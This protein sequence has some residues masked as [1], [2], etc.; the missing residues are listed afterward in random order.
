MITRWPTDRL[1]SLD[2]FSQMMDNMLGVD[3]IRSVWTP[4]VDVKE[5]PTELT[6]IAELPGM[7][8]KDVEVEFLGDVLTV[9]GKRE[10][11]DEQRKD[12]YVRIERNYGSFMRSF[13]LY[14]PV[15]SDEIKASFQNGLLTVIV[16]KAESR[17]AKKIKVKAAE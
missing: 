13:T 12:D 17:P 10:F 9:R 2:R 8:E 7:N 4:V 6:F 15:K 1:R 5:T 11:V 14:V 3:E 16:P